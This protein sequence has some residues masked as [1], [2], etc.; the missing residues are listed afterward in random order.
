VVVLNHTDEELDLDLESRRLLRGQWEPPQSLPPD[1]IRPRESALWHCK[2]TGLGQ[3][4]DGS[5]TYRMAGAVPHDKVRFCWKSRYFGPNQYD[6]AATRDGCVV[7]VMGGEG[8]HAVVVFVLGRC[9]R[10]IG[11]VVPAN[12][13]CRGKG[14]VGYPTAY[15]Q[16]S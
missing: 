8:D 2:A 10:C 6:T 12:A 5:V 15:Q 14:I 1:M 4:I 3:G 9:I 13:G 16:L 7:N 11:S